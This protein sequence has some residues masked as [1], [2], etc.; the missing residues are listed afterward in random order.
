MLIWL[1]TLSLAKPPATQADAVDGQWRA[2][3]VLRVRPEAYRVIKE[4]ITIRE[5]PVE[6]TLTSGVMIPVFSGFHERD[7]DGI[8]Q[9]RAEAFALDSKAPPALEEGDVDFVGF[10]FTAAE[11]TFEVQWQERADSL[12]FANHQVT[13]LKQDREDWVDIAHGAPWTGVVTEGMVLSVDPALRDA[14]VGPDDPEG[15]PEDIV[16]Y[17]EKDYSAARIRARVL[18][19]GR[20]ALMMRKGFHAG[21]GVAWDRVAD[22]FGLKTRG[23]HHI[24]DLH[25]DQNLGSPDLPPGQQPNDIDWITLLQ[26]WTGVLDSRRHSVLTALDLNHDEA[27][28]DHGITGVPFPPSDPEDPVSAPLPSAR[29]ETEE[30][31]IVVQAVPVTAQLK[32]E[33]MARL[34]LKA[35]GGDFQVVQLYVPRHSSQHDWRLKS[36]TDASGAALISRTP[37]IEHNPHGVAPAGAGQKMTDTSGQAGAPQQATEGAIRGQSTNLITGGMGTPLVDVNHTKPES[38][39]TLALPDPI[40]DGETRVVDV[41][42]TDVWPYGDAQFIEQGGMEGGASVLQQNGAASGPQPILPRPA[43]TTRDVATKFQIQVVV[44]DRTKLQVAASGE[45]VKTWEEAGYQYTLSSQLDHPV[46]FPEV[47]IGAFAVHDEA[48]VA[49]LP[50]V[51]TRTFAKDVGKELARET[52]AQINFLQGFLPT[53]PWPEHEVALG[54]S[55]ANRLWWAS[56]HGLTGAGIT[57]VTGVNQGGALTRQGGKHTTQQLMTHELAHQW[58][59]QSLRPP[60]SPMPGSPRPSPRS[61]ACST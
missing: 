12:I 55:G 37:L 17:G 8:R 24:L 21:R 43:G 42:W 6:V 58:F 49:G 57:G 31:F 29:L 1:L 41:R 4:P 38:R 13:H 60:T 15:S 3:Q 54:P 11:G 47:H 35:V 36:I 40:R 9:A 32:V 48:A 22:K 56:G 26:D 10:V 27:L 2:M 16:V 50:A 53:F 51:R 61:S 39:V 59:G 46:P 19:Q 7:R 18:F 30:A 45:L 20:R 44:P 23:Q 33:V 25:I 14:F 5:G 34:K 52:R 28:I